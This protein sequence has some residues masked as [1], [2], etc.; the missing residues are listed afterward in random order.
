MPCKTTHYV[1]KF[2][3]NHCPNNDPTIKPSTYIGASRRAMI[4]R[5]GAHE[6][7]VRRFNDR[8]S[9][10]EHM[11]NSHGDLKPNTISRRVDFKKRFT[12]FTPQVIK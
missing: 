10:G 5:L 4:K 9:L 2:T 6:A 7:S 12:N 11:V 3:C 8:T 1:Y